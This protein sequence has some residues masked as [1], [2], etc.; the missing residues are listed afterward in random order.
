MTKKG[1]SPLIAAV[2]LIAMAIAIATVAGPFFSN[3]LTDLQQDQQ[4]DIESIEASNNARFDIE[5]PMYDTESDNLTLNIQNTGTGNI[6]G[7]KVTVVE[8]SPVQKAFNE[9]LTA[10]E[11]TTARIKSN[12]KPEIVRIT[13]TTPQISAEIKLSDNNL[14]TG[15]APKAP[16]GLDLSD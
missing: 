8:P 4:E 16:T 11:L 9:T 15:S 3:L 12:T 1:V 6:K 13:S 14:A 7:Y 5:N 2:L 10:K